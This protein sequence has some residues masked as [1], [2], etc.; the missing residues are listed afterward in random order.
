MPVVVAL[1]AETDADEG[2]RRPPEPPPQPPIATIEGVVA[3]SGQGF[4]KADAAFGA[5][6]LEGPGAAAM[7]RDAP[8]EA[9]AA[10][11]DEAPAGRE[12]TRDGVQRLMRVVFGMLPGQHHGVA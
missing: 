3:L 8:V 4:P 1:R 10:E 5:A 12:V 2:L 9:V 6:Q 11:V 7:R